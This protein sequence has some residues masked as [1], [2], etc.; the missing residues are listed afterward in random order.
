MLNANVDWLAPV[1]GDRFKAACRY[2]SC[3]LRAHYSDLRHHVRSAKHQRNAKWA[4]LGGGQPPVLFSNGCG[5]FN[6]IVT[7]PF[8]LLLS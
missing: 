6:V 7:F 5:K 4:T 3:I 8:N 1:A 2:C